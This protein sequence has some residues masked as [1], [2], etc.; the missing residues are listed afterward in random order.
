[1]KLRKKGL[2]LQDGGLHWVS[3]F[4]PR[5]EP[6]KF[7]SG[8]DQERPLRPPANHDS[9]L[10][11]F[12]SIKIN[13]QNTLKPSL[14]APSE[15]SGLRLQSGR[16]ARRASKLAIMQR[17]TG[18]GVEVVAMALVVLVALGAFGVG[19]VG[20]VGGVDDRWYSG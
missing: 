17:N 19:G 4:R 11:R 10:L 3:L 16:T 14:Q 2:L 8:F 12:G 15:R 6:S 9:N 13:F 18:R 5:R 7:C 20:G 1:M